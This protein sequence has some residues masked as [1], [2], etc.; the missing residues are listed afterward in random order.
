MKTFALTPKRRKIVKLL[1]F[2]MVSAKMLVQG[3]IFYTTN[4]NKKTMLRNAQKTLQELLEAKYIDYKRYPILETG[5]YR[6]FY[7]L[8]DHVKIGFNCKDSHMIHE[9]LIEHDQLTALFL[10][11]LFR[12]CDRQGISVKWYPPFEIETKTTDGAVTLAKDGKIYQTFILES[13]TGTHDYKEIRQKYEEYIKCLEN[14]P[15]RKILFLV[16][17]TKRRDNLRNLLNDM[18]KNSDRKKYI[19]QIAFI[20][21]LEIPPHAKFF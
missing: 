1:G 2:T 8:P 10:V 6:R 4:G 15:Q 11:H 14:H 12:C 16:K 21:P 7:F 19:K 9:G 20:C 5:K 3:G 17:G 18:L 13:D